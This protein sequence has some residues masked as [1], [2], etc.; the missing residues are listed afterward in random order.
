[1]VTQEKTTWRFLL[2]I[3][4]VFATLASISL[5]SPVPLSA[6]AEASHQGAAVPAP[7][8]QRAPLFTLDDGVYRI[9]SVPGSSMRCYEVVN[10][11][12]RVISSDCRGEKTPR[13]N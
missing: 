10:P 5:V 4:A 6:N 7:V 12:G 2:G 11:Q 8:P 3:L 9:R 1:M 13:S